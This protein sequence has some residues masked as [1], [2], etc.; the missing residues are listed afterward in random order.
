VR[1]RAILCLGVPIQ[2]QRLQFYRRPWCQRFY[3]DFMAPLPCENVLPASPNKTSS[4]Q[5]HQYP[6]KLLPNTVTTSSSQDM[7]QTTSKN[8]TSHKNKRKSISKLFHAQTGSIW[9]QIA[10]YL[11]PIGSYGFSSSQIG[12]YK[13]NG[14][15]TVHLHIHSREAPTPSPKIISIS[16]TKNEPKTSPLYLLVL[17]LTIFPC[18]FC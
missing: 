12:S 8:T 7:G 9:F 11:V 16:G 10:S 2:C 1:F 6:T 3:K 13:L 18:L 17:V 14:F 5:T 15:L 4:A